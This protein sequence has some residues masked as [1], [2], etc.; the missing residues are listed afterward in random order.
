[1]LTLVTAMSSKPESG[2]TSLELTNGE[3]EAG[4]S[5]PAI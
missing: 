2:L 1:M 4:W 5:G 3:L